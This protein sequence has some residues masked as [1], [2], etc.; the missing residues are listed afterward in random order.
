MTGKEFLKLQV[1]MFVTDVENTRLKSDYCLIQ[2]F[3]GK[4]IILLSL[5]EYGQ[6]N[7][8]LYRVDF[9]DYDLQDSMY[10][11]DFIRNTV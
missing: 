1:A 5:D 10:K 9:R 3:K 7:G 2:E 8:K 11:S 4:D 6:P